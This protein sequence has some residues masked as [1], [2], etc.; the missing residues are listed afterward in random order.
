MSEDVIRK[1]FEQEMNVF[2][3]AQTPPALP[4]AHEN[5]AFDPPSDGSAYLKLNLL[6]AQPDNTTIGDGHWRDQGIFQV[7]L[8][9]PQNAGTGDVDTMAKKIKEWFKRGTS[10]NEGGTIV[11]VNKTPTVAPGYPDGEKWKVPVSIPYFAEFFL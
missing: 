9:Y 10:L 7:L 4:L 6:P 5:Q 11:R 1:A 2:V 8:C 3:A